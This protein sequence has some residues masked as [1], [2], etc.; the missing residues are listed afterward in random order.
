MSL[1]LSLLAMRIDRMSSSE[2]KGEEV[3][4]LL[5]LLLDGRGESGQGHCIDG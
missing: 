1:Q 3:L 4:L 5:L 2:G